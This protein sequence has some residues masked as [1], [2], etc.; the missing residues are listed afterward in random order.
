MNIDA[1]PIGRFIKK[2]QRQ[3]STNRNSSIPARVPPITGPKSEEE[4]KTARNMP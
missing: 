1:A 4:P 2:I 3:P